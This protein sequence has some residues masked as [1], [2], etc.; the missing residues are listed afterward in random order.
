MA[1]ATG[2]L[3]D[4]ANSGYW[5]PVVIE[6][7]RHQRGPSGWESRRLSDVILYRKDGATPVTDL[8]LL[9]GNDAKGADEPFRGR[10]F[11][12]LALDGGGVKAI[13]S[14]HVLARLE[15]DLGLTLIDHFD[16]VAGTSAGG[17]IALA[18]GAGL[19]PAEIFDFYEE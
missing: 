16:L 7:R 15:M 2:G 19:R 13:F 11:H 9:A 10:P 8:S 1:V 3:E 17:V 5:V 6:V 14:A 4:R 18:L 12:I